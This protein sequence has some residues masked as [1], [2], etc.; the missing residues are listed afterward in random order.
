MQRNSGCQQQGSEGMTARCRQDLGLS[1]DAICIHEKIRPG[2]ICHERI[3]SE[4][5]V[6][7]VY[8]GI[9]STDGRQ[10]GQDLTASRI[11]MPDAPL[12]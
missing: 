8:P 1:G 6:L 7:Q 10:A 9:L 11:T 2:F 12:S 3:L 5:N 4:R